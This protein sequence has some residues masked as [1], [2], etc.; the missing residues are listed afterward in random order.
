MSGWAVLSLIAAAC[1]PVQQRPAPRPAPATVSE[2]PA[3]PVQ[4]I[5]GDSTLARITPVRGGRIT[6]NTSNADLRDLLPLLANAAGVN[7][8][9]GPEVYGRVSVRFQNV[10]AIDALRAVIEQAGLLVGDPEMKLPWGKSVFYDLPVNV[11]TASATTIRSRFDVST[12]LSEWV[13]KGR[14][15]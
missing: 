11:N 6:L 1:A 12:T 8:V 13:V 5:V 9:M 14:V 15:Y 3:L 7:L 2:L 4:T 10:L